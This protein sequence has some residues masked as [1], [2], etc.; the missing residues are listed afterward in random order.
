VAILNFL[1]NFKKKTLQ[2][3]IKINKKYDGKDY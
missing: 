2:Q 3:Q 1:L